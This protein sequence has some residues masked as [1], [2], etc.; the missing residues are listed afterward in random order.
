M[1]LD[2]CAVRSLR[3]YQR[4]AKNYVSRSV[5]TIIV[6]LL[7]ENMRV[8]SSSGTALGVV[9]L[10]GLACFKLKSNAVRLLRLS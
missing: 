4:S 1:E 9:F 3:G 2:Y 7:K 6:N 10:C 5:P 8:Y